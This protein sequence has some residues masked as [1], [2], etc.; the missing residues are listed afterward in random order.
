MWCVVVGE[1]RFL[2][3]WRTWESVQ[4]QIIRLIERMAMETILAVIVRNVLRM[5]G[6][7]I[8][9]GLLERSKGETR[10]MLGF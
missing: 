5:D 3:F 2:S 1:A 8:A 4:V 10:K 7:L 9:V 6:Q